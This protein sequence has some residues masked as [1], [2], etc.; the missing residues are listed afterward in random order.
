ARPDVVVLGERAHPVRELPRS[1]RAPHLLR[2]RGALAME[3]HVAAAA[4]VKVAIRDAVAFAEGLAQGVRSDT[5]PEARHLAGH[6][7]AEDP[8]VDRQRERRVPAPEMEIRAADV[9]ERHADEHGAR[10]K[11]GERQLAELEGLAWPVE[12]GGLPAAG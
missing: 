11:L 1:G 7:V 6:L 5:G 8:A 12:H 4:R 2:A 10:L 3:A 9:R